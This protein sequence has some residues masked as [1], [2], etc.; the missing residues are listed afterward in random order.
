MKMLHVIFFFMYN[1]N[2]IKLSQTL[3]NSSDQIPYIETFFRYSI[4]LKSALQSTKNFIYDKP[5]LIYLVKDNVT[6]VTRYLGQR[7]S[8]FSLNKSLTI[9][10]SVYYQV[11]LE[12][13]YFSITGEARS[14][15]ST[16]FFKLTSRK[17]G[18]EMRQSNYSSFNL[19]S[20]KV[21]HDTLFKACTFNF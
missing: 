19:K 9:V 8:K 3:S 10:Y 13:C 20:K 4:H 11:T 6:G 12:L 7:F 5:S 1:H 16:I 21:F 14:F 18:T 17:S 15:I 2:R